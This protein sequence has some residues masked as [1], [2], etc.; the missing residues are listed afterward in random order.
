AHVVTS[1]LGDELD[2]FFA[3]GETARA[4]LAAVAGAR[5]YL[6][7]DF[8][9]GGSHRLVWID[10]AMA[11]E[12]M[13]GCAPVW[14]SRVPAGEM[15]PMPHVAAPALALEPRVSAELVARRRW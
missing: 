5:Y 12:V 1:V 13:R 14:L 7:Q 8:D 4:T 10:E 6:V 9:E 2:R 15:L 11:G 3:T